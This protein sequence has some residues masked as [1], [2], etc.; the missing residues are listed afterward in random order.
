[1]RWTRPKNGDTRKIKRFAFL[2]IRIHDDV[3][4]L[5]VVYIKQVFRIWQYMMPSREWVNCSFIDR[6]EYWK[7]KKNEYSF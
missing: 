5:E 1:M 4:W 7:E 6:D 2:P 3:R